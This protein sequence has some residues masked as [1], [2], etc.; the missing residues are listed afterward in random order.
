[1]IS[2]NYF[3]LQQLNTPLSNHTNRAVTWSEK[4]GFPLQSIFS[5]FTL[6]C[7]HI[8]AASERNP[9]TRKLLFSDP[10][11][12]GSFPGKGRP[13]APT[14]SP[15]PGGASPPLF[16]LPLAPELPPFLGAARPLQG[17]GLP[18]CLPPAKSGVWLS[19]PCRRRPCR[20][21][22]TMFVELEIAKR[23]SRMG[24]ASRRK[25][26]RLTIDRTA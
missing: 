15:L 24:I 2:L 7:N 14:S 13:L 17:L 8:T 1:M 20:K 25:M 22:R 19:R 16:S 21:P 18:P 12:F 5:T 11:D 23:L 4:D 3:I 6:S 10:Q 26:F 9:T